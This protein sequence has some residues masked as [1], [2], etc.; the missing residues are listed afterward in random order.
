M[1]CLFYFKVLFV[2]SKLA[3]FFRFY[4]VEFAEVNDDWRLI[5]IRMMQRYE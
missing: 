2:R 5:I 1:R 3:Y 4:Y